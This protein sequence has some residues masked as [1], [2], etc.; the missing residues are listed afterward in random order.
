LRKSTSVY[1]DKGLGIIFW[2]QNIL[3]CILEPGKQKD[4]AVTIRTPVIQIRHIGRVDNPRANALDFFFKDCTSRTVLIKVHVAALVML[5]PSF[6]ARCPCSCVGACVCV[7]VCV[8]VGVCVFTCVCMCTC[9][10]TRVCVC[11]YTYIYTHIYLSFVYGA[12]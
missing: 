5:D 9:V 7:C 6:A 3:P 10:R 11:V 1:F 2:R 4:G 8:C 12:R